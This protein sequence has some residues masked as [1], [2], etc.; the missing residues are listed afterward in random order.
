MRSAGREGLDTS[1]LGWALGRAGF[2]YWSSSPRRSESPSPALRIPAP[3]RCGQRCLTAR[4]GL[5]G[6][7]PA[8]PSSGE[9]AEGQSSCPQVGRAV[10]R[11]LRHQVRGALA[12]AGCA[13]Y[14]GV[15]VVCHRLSSS[16]NATYRSLAAREQVFWN[17]AA[18]RAVF[19]IQGTAAGLWALLLDPV[20]QADKALGQQ[21][22]CWFHITTAT[23][24]FFFE[25]LALHVSNALFHTFDGFL[26]V[27]HLFA[28]LGFLGSAVN[29][30]AGHYLPMVT[31]LLEMSTPF[32]CIS[33]MLL[34]AG[35]ANSRLWRLNQWAMVH[36]FHCR[37][38]LTYHMWWVCLGHWA[39]LAHSLFPPHLA[40]FVVGLALL[41]LLINP[42]WT[43]KK[44]QQL[45]NPVDW[46]FAPG[47]PNGPAQ[48]KKAR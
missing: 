35:C 36:L 6:R 15:F 39:G 27:H 48:P 3:T 21:D 4:P 38:V 9:H 45:L 12:A 30:Q 41:T 22:W 32:T 18:T 34:K 16:L 7:D 28:F 1:L 5:W 10:V 11:S 13:F 19:G 42:Y 44:T 2:S 26:A 29:L 23:G 17:L 25:N 24:F 33:W 43:R 47:T 40:L 37:M 46:N 14:L 8:R 31:L 20:L